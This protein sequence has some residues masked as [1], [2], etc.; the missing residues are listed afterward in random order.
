MNDLFSPS[1]GI[2]L[3]YNGN[4]FLLDVAEGNL[5]SLNAIYEIAG[6][7]VN[8]DPRRWFETEQARELVKILMKKLDV[9][10]NV[11]VKTSRGG[12][13]GGHG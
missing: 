3:S 9:A 8:Q 10:K 11:I 5:I 1:T 2:N 7:P 13:G 6:C 12:R 4:R